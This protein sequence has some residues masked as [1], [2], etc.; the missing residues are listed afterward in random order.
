MLNVDSINPDPQLSTALAIYFARLTLPVWQQKYP[1]DSRPE[2]AIE[3]AEK[4]LF[5][6]DIS[7]AGML[8]L[9]MLPV[10]LVML[11]LK[12]PVPLLLLLLMLPV[13]LVML[14]LKLPVLVLLIVL[15]V[16]VK[17]L[18]IILLIE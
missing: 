7:F 13:L 8:L 18:P 3:A 4:A 10:L 12:L 17:L 5:V 11:L 1:E 15:I 16:P 2:R 14:L 9:L 6:A